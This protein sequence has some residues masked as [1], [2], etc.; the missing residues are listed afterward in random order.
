MSI[1]PRGICDG[2]ALGPIGRRRASRKRSSLR[3]GAISCVGWNWYLNSCST[4]AVGRSFSCSAASAADSAPRATSYTATPSRFDA[5]HVAMMISG[6]PS[7]S[8][9]TSC[10]QQ[11]NA[12]V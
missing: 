6:S 2:G 12:A 11:A 4:G 3:L 5:K 7:V 10:A 8:P 1:T 9:K